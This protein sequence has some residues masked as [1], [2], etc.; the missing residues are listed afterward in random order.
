MIPEPKSFDVLR[1]QKFFPRFIPLNSARQTMLKTVELDIQLRV[2][3]VKI[4]DMSANGVLPAKFEAGE[5][6]PSQ[7]L[8]QFFFLVGLI[9]AKFAGDLFEVHVGR[10]QIVGKNSSSSPPA[11]SSFG[12]ER[13][14]NRASEFH[15]YFKPL[16]PF[17]QGEGDEARTGMLLQISSRLEFSQFFPQHFCNRLNGLGAEFKLAA[18]RP[19]QFRQRT[20][21]A[22]RQGFLVFAQRL[23][24]IAF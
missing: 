16:N 8:P 10:M 2:S 24:L 9:A 23:R 21:A 1:R 17:W 13:V 5:L 20:R 6:P 15:A 7:C 11:L 22:E 4:Q 18:R 19:K 3:A 12:E 14:T